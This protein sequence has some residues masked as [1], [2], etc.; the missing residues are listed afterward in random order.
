MMSGTIVLID[1][2]HGVETPGKRSPDERLLEWKW[3][4]IVARKAAERLRARGVDVRLLVEE[5]RDVSLRERAG[6]ANALEGEI[7]L[8]SI[9]ANAAGRGE[10]M[11][12]RGWSAFVAQN[13]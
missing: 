3:T 1:N 6:R 4:R 10:W 11:G 8:V 7:L 13:A 12:A 2:G 9:H 5:V